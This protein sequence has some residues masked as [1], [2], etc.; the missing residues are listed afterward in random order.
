[1]SKTKSPIKVT[2]GKTGPSKTEHIK[3]KVCGLNEIS[4]IGS[5]AAWEG[6]GPYEVEPGWRSGS[7]RLS[8]EAS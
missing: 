8:L 3:I 4:P 1:M 2:Y 6:C 7:L 5:H